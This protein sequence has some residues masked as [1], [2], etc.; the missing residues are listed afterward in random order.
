MTL[1]RTAYKL[2]KEMKAL[3]DLFEWEAILKVL[4]FLLSQTSWL[5]CSSYFG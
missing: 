4:P 5:G 3:Q 2:G 1:L